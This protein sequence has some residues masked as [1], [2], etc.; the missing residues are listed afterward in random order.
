ME[1]DDNDN[2]DEK[3]EDDNDNEEEEVEVEVEVEDNKEDEEGFFSMKMI[4]KGL[5]RVCFNHFG[6]LC[7]MHLMGNRII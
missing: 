6:L 5:V 3:E 7:F 2:K 4:Q 1:E